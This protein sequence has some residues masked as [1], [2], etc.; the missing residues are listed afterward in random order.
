MERGNHELLIAI[1]LLKLRDFIVANASKTQC[2]TRSDTER[3]NSSS[4]KIDL[5][6]CF[7]NLASKR[8]F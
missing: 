7:K 6:S 3:N 8:A 1:R 2:V 4:Q 5:F